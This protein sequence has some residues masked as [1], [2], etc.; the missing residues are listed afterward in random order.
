[1]TDSKNA[2]PLLVIAAMADAERPEGPVVLSRLLDALKAAA[3]R[4]QP[5]GRER[6][7]LALLDTLDP[8][9]N[10]TEVSIASSFLLKNA[11]NTKS[12]RALKAGR[13]WPTS[14]ST[15]ICRQ[16][17]R[18]ERHEAMTFRVNG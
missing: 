2:E 6:E 12:S 9:L 4:R 1:M 3:G 18:V 13:P 14:S 11:K 15:S 16:G 5:S 8:L 7:L 10:G 17:H